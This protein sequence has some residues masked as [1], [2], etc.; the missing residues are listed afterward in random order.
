LSRGE[1]RLEVDDLALELGD[2][3]DRY[4]AVAV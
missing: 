3:V 2:L 1:L 4:G